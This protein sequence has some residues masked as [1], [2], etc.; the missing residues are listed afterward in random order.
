MSPSTI[1]H[2]CSILYCCVVCY[3]QPLQPVP[4]AVRPVN[5]ST[6][7]RHSP[8]PCVTRPQNYWDNISTLAGEV[9]NPSRNFPRALLWAVLLVVASY[10]LPTMAALGVLPEAGDWELGYYGKVAQQVGRGCGRCV[11]LVGK[12]GVLPGSWTVHG[13]QV[14][15]ASYGLQPLQHERLTGLVFLDLGSGQAKG[16]AADSDLPSSV[17]C[18]WVAT[19]WLGGWWLQPPPPRSVSSRR[20]CLRTP[21]SC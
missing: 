5:S 4:N 17:A 16:V 7:V 2:Y 13:V 15:S 12:R 6:L 14:S 1:C 8:H 19:G 11:C 21:T 9:S 10:L 20:K 18:R 3:Y